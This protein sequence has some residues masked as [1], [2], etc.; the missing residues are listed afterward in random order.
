MPCKFSKWQYTYLNLKPRWTTLSFW[1][2][3]PCLFPYYPSLPYS[4]PNQNIITLAWLT[5]PHYSYIVSRNYLGA[6]SDLEPLSSG[7]NCFKTG[8][9]ITNTILISLI[10]SSCC[11]VATGLARS[12]WSSFIINILNAYKEGLSENNYD[13]SSEATTT[14]L[15]FFCAA[16]ECGHSEQAVEPFF[17]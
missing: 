12:L 1:G 8:M 10:Y 5:I 17:I 14:V 15:G 16:F 4:D 3:L 13:S 7:Q 6:F 11:S 9:I 2:P